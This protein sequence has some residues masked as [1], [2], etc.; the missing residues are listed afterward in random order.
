MQ[1]RARR[2]FV[3]SGAKPGYESQPP[4][5]VSDAAAS[6]KID[7][8][9]QRTKLTRARSNKAPSENRSDKSTKVRCA[10]CRAVLYSRRLEQH[11]HDVHKG[12]GLADL[13]EWTARVISPFEFSWDGVVYKPPIG[14]EGCISRTAGGYLFAPYQ[15]IVNGQQIFVWVLPDDVELTASAPLRV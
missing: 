15:A 1:G 9:K 10:Y 8:V 12:I 2:A 7:R 4:R 3:S 6:P 13:P 14:V 11:F 5:G